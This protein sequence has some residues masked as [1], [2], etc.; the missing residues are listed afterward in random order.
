MVLQ[1]S[2]FGHQVC[3]GIGVISDCV[4]IGLVAESRVLFHY[5]V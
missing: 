4:G 3:L 5:P 1:Q 2:S